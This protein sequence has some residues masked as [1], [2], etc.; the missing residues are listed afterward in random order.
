MKPF[1]ASTP[2][3]CC[4][5]TKDAFSGVTVVQVVSSRPQVLSVAFTSTIPAANGHSLSPVLLDPHTALG[6]EN[7]AVADA[8]LST[9]VRASGDHH[10]PYLPG[11]DDSGRRCDLD[12][13]AGRSWVW[14]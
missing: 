9:A 14:T 10:C 12:V 8:C 4:S 1:N 3:Y 7:T 5:S 13:E 6:F 11:P 2:C